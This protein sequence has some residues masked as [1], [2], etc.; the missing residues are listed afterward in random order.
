V[1]K[2][3]YGGYVRVSEQIRDWSDPDIISLLLDDMARVYGDTTD[4]VA[5]DAFVTAATQTLAFPGASTDA[6][7]W[8]TWLYDAAEDILTN[9][10]GHLP[11]HLFLGTGNWKNLG[12]LE[13]DQGRPL[14]PQ[15]G[16]MNALGT[17]T[18]GTANFT[19]FGLQVVVDRNFDSGVA[20]L[21]DTI[22]FEIFEQTKG[23]LSVDNGSTRSRDISWLGYLST[24]ML[25]VDR[26][27]KAV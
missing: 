22:G 2:A 5:A 3:S 18:P 20:I 24:L 11:T 21:G 14:F 26:Y 10:T 16:P 7:N 8:L 12:K 27:V 9:S 25:D 6:T 13:D 4:N 15:V 23:F 1:T 19:A 17:T